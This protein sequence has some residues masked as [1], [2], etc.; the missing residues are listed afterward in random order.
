M[1]LGASALKILG[2]SIIGFRQTAVSQTANTA[3]SF[4]AANPRTG[5]AVGPS[6]FSSGPDDIDL[7]A[8]LADRAF[9]IYGGASGRERGNF[10]R[11]IADKIDAAV[12]ALVERAELESALPRPRLI[13]ETAR[14]SGQLRLFA[15]VA[16]EGSW[17]MAR[18]DRGDPDRKPVPKPDL[19]S[20]LHPLGPVAIFGASNFP[21]AFS[22][23]GGDTASALAAGNPVI[24]K[25]HPA[26]P[27]TSEL[28]GQLVRESVRE[29]GLPEG[30]FSLLFDSGNKVGIALIKHSLVKAVGF[31]GSRNGGRAL[32]DVA[33]ARPDPIPV[34]AEMSSTNPVFILPGALRE[35]SDA[36]ATGLH[37]SV[38]IGAGQFCTK[39]GM[40]FLAEGV[41]DESFM[42][43]LQKQVQESKP[44]N[45]LTAGIRSAYQ[46]S[47]ARRKAEKGVKLSAE[48]SSVSGAEIGV[49][50]ALF[51]T[52]VHSFLQNPELAAEVFGPATL[53]IRHSSR[54]QL[55]EV[56]SRLEGHLTATIHGTQDDLREF[57]DLLAI[58]KTKVGRIVFNGFPT[59]VEVSHAMVHGG[60]Y[61]ATSDGRTTSVGS[62]AIFRFCRPVCYQGFPQAALPDEL[63]DRNPHQ[64]WRMVDGKMT[65]E[66]VG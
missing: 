1:V 25:A 42:A 36:I 12:D 13:G 46:A 17:V 26:H 9:A 30:V 65:K 37:A 23:A 45:L 62:Q 3:E 15:D 41:S 51:E 35:K 44:F 29:C 63:K 33:A 61:P 54:A 10:L 52:D 43:S 18:I 4:V 39:P 49:N 11:T 60:P 19:R 7:A 40:V 28:V 64:I 38:T 6:F 8:S 24:V 56:A 31:T 50:P 20:M 22:V 5:E 32:M 47:I 48:R 58:V 16:E 2:Q 14:T 21:L 34:F 27:G 55:L 57:S 66:P 53:L 59:G